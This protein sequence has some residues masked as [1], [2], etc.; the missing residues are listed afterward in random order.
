MCFGL[1]NAPAEF[2]RY[3]SDNLREVLNDFVIVYFD[4]I[5]I[6]SEDLES[7]WEKEGKYWKESGKRKSTL[8]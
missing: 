1:K 6:F 5:I 7:H 8:N 2:A 3:M 4:D